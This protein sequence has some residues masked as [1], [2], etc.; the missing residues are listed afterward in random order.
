MNRAGYTKRIVRALGRAERCC[1]GNAIREIAS[2]IITLGHTAD[3]F[4]LPHRWSPE[5][6]RAVVLAY[7]QHAP[8]AH[9]AE[10]ATQADAQVLWCDWYDAVGHIE[11]NNCTPLLPSLAEARR[12]S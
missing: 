6:V 1:D 9:L 8:I 12:W 7:A 2:C 4:D 11:G 5:A 3:D 10:M